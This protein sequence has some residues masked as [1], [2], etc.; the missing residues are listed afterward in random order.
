MKLSWLNKKFFIFSFLFIFLI[1]LIFIF[2]VGDKSTNVNLATKQIK[3]KDKI[4]DVEIADTTRQ[5]YL[6]LSYREELPEKMGLLFVFLDK[7]PRTFIMRNMKFALDIVFIEE[8]TIVYICPNLPPNT[9]EEEFYCQ[10]D[11]LVDKVLEVNAGFCE[12]NEIEIG[13][14]IY[15]LK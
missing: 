2:K 7:Q 9:K 15:F 5:Q 4:I 11:L 13:D 1:F 3:I 6:G 12:E 8:N 10:S 14:V